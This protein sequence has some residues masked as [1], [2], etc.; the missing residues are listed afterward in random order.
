MTL[1]MNGSIS[2]SPQSRLITPFQA[3]GDAGKTGYCVLHIIY[4]VSRRLFISEFVQKIGDYFTK[5][6]FSL[7]AQDNLILRI[8][9]SIQQEIPLHSG[10]RHWQTELLLFQYPA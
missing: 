9:S 5:T 3:A 1:K 6:F 2:C 10:I 7:A 4:D 8:L